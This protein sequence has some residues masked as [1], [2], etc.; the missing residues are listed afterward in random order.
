MVGVEPEDTRRKQVKNQGLSSSSLSSSLGLLHIYD[1]YSHFNCLGETVE[2]RRA[3]LLVLVYH[4]I[5]LSRSRNIV[6]ITG[7]VL[8]FVLLMLLLFSYSFVF[9][10]VC[11]P[12]KLCYYCLVL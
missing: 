8:L 5:Y 7:E 11:F 6:Y 12:S 9:V 3:E 4:M 10:V 1:L 2:G